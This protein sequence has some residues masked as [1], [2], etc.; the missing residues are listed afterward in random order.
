MGV[1]VPRLTAILRGNVELHERGAVR[2]LGAR[3]ALPEGRE[4]RV[5]GLQV[6]ARATRSRSAAPSRPRRGCRGAPSRARSRP[7]CRRPGPTSRPPSRRIRP[8]VTSLRTIASPT[9]LSA[10]IPG[11]CGSSTTG[12]SLG[13]GDELLQ[14]AIADPLEVLVVLEDAAEGGVD[15]ADLELL[16]SERDERLRPVDRLGDTRDLREVGQPQT[17]D[18]RRGLGGEP[19]GDAR[20]AGAHDRDLAVERGV[21][22]PVVE[23]AALERVVQLA[24]AVRGQHHDRPPLGADR[25]DLGD[26]DLEVGEELEQE[27][28]ELVVGPVDLVDQQHRAA[29]DRRARS[30]RAAAGARGTR[31]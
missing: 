20:H 8:N 31:G 29:P 15:D 18:E 2:D 21:S 11:A 27:G 7:S 24:R 12:R 9:R 19:L 28:L 4:R 1:D 22:D 26:R 14:P 6:V 5:E 16:L 23:A 10:C 30:R 3:R 25:A 17:L 13:L